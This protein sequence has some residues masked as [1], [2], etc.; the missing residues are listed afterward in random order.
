[1][2][3]RNG[4]RDILSGVLKKGIGVAQ[5]AGEARLKARKETVN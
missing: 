1:M 5:R 3:S 2:E 4:A